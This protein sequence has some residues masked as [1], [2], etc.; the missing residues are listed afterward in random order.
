M[1]M[2]RQT[3]VLA[4]LMTVHQLSA[5]QDT[6]LM[7]EAVVTANKYPSKTTLTG[8][9][10]TIINA[11]QLAKAGSKDLSQLLTEQAGIY[12]GGANSNAG[13]DKSIYVWGA[14]PANCLITIDGIPVYDP[15]AIGGNFD[16]RNISIAAIE[17]IEIVKGS[18]S[19]LYGSNAIAGVINIIT[20]K[21]ANNLLKAEANAGYG[22]YGTFKG[23]A[24]IRGQKGIVDYDLDYS[25]LKTRGINETIDLSNSNITDRDG[26]RQE[27]IQLGLG[28]IAGSHI[29]SR[30]FF[31]YGNLKGSIDQGAYTDE[32]DY[33][34]TQKSW[35]A[36]IKNEGNFGK[37]KLTLLYQYNRIDR[38]YIDDSVKSRNGFDI[39][40]SGKYNG[41]EHLADLYAHYF[42]DKNF[43]FTI[44]ADW[45]RSATE[46]EYISIPAYGLP[47]LLDTSM[48]QESF[49]GAVNYNSNRGFN[50]ELG[51][52]IN[53]H[54]AYG[55]HGV[56]NINPS[57]L[58][59]KKLKLFANYSTA[60]RTPSLYQLYSEY[61]NNKLKPEAGTSLEGG[62]QYFAF[63]NRL[64]ARA[65]VFERK[66]KDGIFFYYNS[67]TF[68][69]QYIN[70][71]KQK[72]HGLEAELNFRIKASL[73]LH[74]SYNY[75]TGQVSTKNAGKDTS[76]FNLLRRPKHAAGFTVS[77]Q[78]GRQLFIS[79]N[80]FY[81]GKRQDNY[82]D[83]NSFST[84][85][86]VLPSYA[87]WNVYADYTLK[88]TQLKL[89]LDV[90]NISNTH[91]MEIAGFRTL[92]M[93]GSI[94]I[95]W[96]N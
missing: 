48:K 36:G 91:Y 31:R 3:F 80:L 89:F 33:T 6:T 22:S 26:F 38:L 43:K 8:K 76:Y 1:K 96:S 69:S 23:H 44:G 13:K 9:V 87:L 86:V 15:S 60:Y 34:Y 63:K 20:K 2:K 92:A 59:G 71:D 28:I 55:N 42:L 37:L 58:L 24:G 67:A 56:Y 85:S 66:L 11:E 17:R 45:R 68:S 29:V 64:T 81:A 46:Q 25:Y 47:S 19:T 12:I 62:L 27:N 50:L 88:N 21:A 35:Q 16:I 14:S 41:G 51:G 52:R 40:S 32:L 84:V 77:Y 79:S 93:N 65:V 53:F 75:V 70:Q 7:N 49:Y 5:Q 61:G 10:I 39:Y 95:R 18:Q 72:D 54:S 82:F 90:R 4:A 73:Q 30:G 94:G 57:Y 78:A 83:S 74:A